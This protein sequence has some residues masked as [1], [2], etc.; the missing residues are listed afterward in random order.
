MTGITEYAHKEREFAVK[1]SAMEIYNEVVRV[2]LSANATPLRV[3][4]D[5]KKTCLQGLSLHQA[6]RGI[7]H[8]FIAVSDNNNGD[9]FTARR[10]LD[11]TARAASAS[12]TIEA[13]AVEGGG[14]TAKAG[15]KAKDQVLY[16]SSFFGDELL[17]FIGAEVDVKRLPKRPAPPRFGRKL[18]ETQ[19]NFVDLVGSERAS[20]ALSAGTRL[21][22]G[23]HI[24]RSL[25]TLGTVIRKLR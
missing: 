12:K 19:K 25:L 9:S 2:L 13:E 7:S 23:S 11:I 5:P 20:Q 8:S 3:L 16:T 24:N 14:N 22:E 4:D 10:R 18:T 17:M 15:L 21:R 1:F 6:K